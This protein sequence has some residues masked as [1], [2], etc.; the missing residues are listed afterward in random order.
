MV[1]VKE[2]RNI[3]EGLLKLKNPNDDPDC[4]ITAC[5]IFSTFLTV[6]GSF[7]FGVAIGYTSGAEIGMIKDMDLSIAEFSAF[8]SFCTLGGT[9][10][11]LLSGKMAIVLGRRGTMWVADILCVIGW[12]CIA[13][14]KDVLWL[15]IGRISSG[16][17]IGL[18]SYVVVPVYIAEITPKHVRGTCTFSTQL[19]QNAGLAMV[20]FLGNFISWRM[21]ALLGA[22]PCVIQ[23]I[24]LFFIPESPRWLAKVGA[25]KELENSLLRLRGKDVDISR[26]ASEIQVMTKMLESDSKSSFSNLFQRKYRHTLVVGVGL[27]LIQ[28]FSGSTAV[29]SYASTIIRK[30]GFS[31]AI[32]ST[33]LA[34]FMVPKAMIGVIFVDKW[35]R[36]PLL[37]TSACGMS[38]T[39]MFIGL[40]FTL[41]QKMHLLSEVTPVLTFICVTLYL[42]AYAIGVGGLP[43]VIMSEIFPMNMKVTAGSLVT[44]ASWSSSS[45]V[46]YA[47]NF[48][49]EWST[50]GTF[51][52][53]GAIAGAALVFIWLFVPETK[54]LSLEEIQTSLIR[55]PDE[56][57]HM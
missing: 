8:G 40:A 53:F 10:G 37:L 52:I 15:N 45:I 5:V 39:C 3:E 29:F 16:I 50:R 21:M 31:V 28:Q 17:G 22:L 46:T 41:Q 47:F 49:F 26:E 19:L 36:R 38:I 35:G 33:L 13:F 25:D 27:M 34:I 11:A 1:A 32:G 24:G 54:G 44:L 20:Y 23:G 4:R 43:W 7:S 2:K 6:C 30:A 9:F 48:L 51:Y 42:A 18:I 55:E 57:Y 56:I 14:A 12:L